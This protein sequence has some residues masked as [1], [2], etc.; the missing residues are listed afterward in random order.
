MGSRPPPREHRARATA[1]RL[2]RAIAVA[3]ALL[4]LS[5]ATLG[6]GEAVHAGTLV[7]SPDEASAPFPGYVLENFKWVDRTRVDLY[8]SW[9]GG[10]CVLNGTDLS[11]PASAL[12]AVIAQQAF[13]ASIQQINAELRGGLTLVDAG[14]ATRAELCTQDTSY[15]IVIGWGQIAETGR[16]VYSGVPSAT[17]PGWSDLRSA[18]VFLSDAYD[19]ACPG[20]PTYRDLQHT[21]THELLHTIG[22]GHSLDPTAIMAPTD[23][24]CQT[25]YLLQPDD[26]AALAVL[27]PPTVTAPSPGVGIVGALDRAITSV[28]VTAAIWNGGTVAQLAAAVTAAGGVSV[29]TFVGGRSLVLIPGAPAFVNATFDAAFPSGVP[30]GTIVLVVR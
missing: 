7:G 10:T 11:G 1:A 2:G 29:T 6:G 22:V 25:P 12:S 9:G 8:S 5:A 24:A 15:A 27:Y 20:S 16:A 4:A 17:Q 19:F 18:R 3:V 13:D 26:I 30:T 21:I 23:I 14:P 28:G